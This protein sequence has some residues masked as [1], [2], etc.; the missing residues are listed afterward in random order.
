MAAATVHAHTAEYIGW[1]SPRC[2]RSAVTSCN[3]SSLSLC[4][5]T[6]SFP[7]SLTENESRI[8]GCREQQPAQDEDP[9][10]APK[11][12]RIRI[13]ALVL[14][15]TRTATTSIN[16][17][18]LTTKPTSIGLQ[19]RV[20]SSWNYCRLRTTAADSAYGKVIRPKTRQHY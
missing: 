8:V 17:K 16:K 20:Y 10:H 18:M 15:A 9:K 3:Q 12:P 4:F 14:T 6:F 7:L 13:R 11:N 5:R 1:S 19:E 2:Q